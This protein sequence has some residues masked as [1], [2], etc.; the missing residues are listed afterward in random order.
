[1]PLGV[2]WEPAT[3]VGPSLPDWANSVRMRGSVWRGT[4]VVFPR[5]VRPKGECLVIVAKPGERLQGER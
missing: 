3:H 5:Q 1:M 4:P 2:G